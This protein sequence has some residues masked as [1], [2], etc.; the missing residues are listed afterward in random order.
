LIEP[1]NGWPKHPHTD[2]LVGPHRLSR[3]QQEQRPASGCNCLPSPRS[4]TLP[5]ISTLAS[6]PCR[7]LMLTY[8]EPARETSSDAIAWRKPFALLE[9]VEQAPGLEARFGRSALNSKNSP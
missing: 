9:L 8:A 3:P 2:G 1:S 5:V 4:G 6:T 7:D